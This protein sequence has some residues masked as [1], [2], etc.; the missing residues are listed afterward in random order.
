MFPN[1]GM[2]S[3]DVTVSKCHSRKLD[4]F[5]GRCII[6]SFPSVSSRSKIIDEE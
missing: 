3:D 4:E 2:S 6:K 5:T 1:V